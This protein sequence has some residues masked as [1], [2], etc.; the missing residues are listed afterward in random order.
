M[1]LMVSMYRQVGGGEPEPIPYDEETMK[2]ITI[3]YIYTSGEQSIP[4]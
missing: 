4:F 2:Y 1:Q 3:K